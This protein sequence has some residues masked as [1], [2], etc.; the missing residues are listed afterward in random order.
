MVSTADQKS[1]FPH[2][3]PLSCRTLH[4]ITRQATIRLLRDN[5]SHSIRQFVNALTT[6]STNHSNLDFCTSTSRVQC[7]DSA[8]ISTCKAETWTGLEMETSEL[9]DTMMISPSLHGR[10]HG[11]LHR[12]FTSRH[13]LPSG[14]PREAARTRLLQMRLYSRNF[15]YFSV[16]Y[17]YVDSA[18][19][20]RLQCR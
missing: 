15:Y 20:K 17:Q 7:P 10:Q 2:V 19:K 14:R 1:C 6:K 16:S 13:L 4:S 8:V 11:Y 12:C 18:S 5:T 9:F 3:G